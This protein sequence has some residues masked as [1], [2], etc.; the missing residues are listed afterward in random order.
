VIWTALTSRLAPY[1]LALKFGLLAVVFLVGCRAGCSWQAGR[2]AKTIARKEAALV[3]ASARLMA[4]SDAL[5]SVNAHTAAEVARAEAS[6]AQNAQAAADADRRAK[7][8]LA[9]LVGVERD[10]ELA[11]RQSPACRA[12]LEERP[13]ASLH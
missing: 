12:R 3:D 13:C 11:K 9:R 2:D 4:A 5:R 7:D 8:Y 10:L 6:R 1:A